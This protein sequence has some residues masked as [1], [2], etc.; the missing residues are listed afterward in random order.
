VARKRL[1]GSE[2]DQA[3]VIVI[4][5]G[6][7]HV[8]EQTFSGVKLRPYAARIQTSRS[9]SVV[10]RPLQLPPLPAG[11]RAAV[12]DFIAREEARPAAGDAAVELPMALAAVAVRGK[13]AASEANASVAL[14]QRFYSE[15]LELPLREEGGAVA[16]AASGH[17]GSAG[18]A[19]P[20]A[21][22]SAAASPLAGR[23][24]AA[25]TAGT[26]DAVVAGQRAGA[27]GSREPPVPAATARPRAPPPRRLAMADLAPPA[28]PF[29]RETFGKPTWVR[30][31]L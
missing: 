11:R 25:S 7:P 14:V 24:G 21:P 17:S 8:L 22:S 2:F 19:P 4:D 28:Q 1:G 12:R 20:A 9:K 30:D 5:K 3:G 13:Q 26:A 29:A 15:A 6:A 23:L 31:V 16:A 27:A 18:G 10:V